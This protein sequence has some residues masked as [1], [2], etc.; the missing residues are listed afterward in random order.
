MNR[1]SIVFALTILLAVTTS[2][3]A[4]V[5]SGRV[6]LSSYL[7]ERSELDSTDTR[8]WQNSGTIGLRLGRI[9]GQDLEVVTT[10]R[11]RLDSRNQGDNVDDYRVYD[12]F[13]RWRKLGGVIDATVGRHRISW[14]SG[15]VGI[16]GGSADLRFLKEWEVGGYIGS[17]VPEDGRFKSTDFDEGHAIGARLGR[18][19]KAV[20]T[21]F[22]TFSERRVARSYGDTDV[23]TLASRI[24]GVDWRRSF[25][26]FG[27]LYANVLYDQ[28]RMRISRAQVSGRWDATPSVSVQGQ[29]RYRRPDLAYN[30]IFWVF[31]DSDYMEER[32]RLLIR[33][34]DHWSMTVGGAL[35]DIGDDN[36]TRFDI[37]ASHRYLSAM[38]HAK[39]G[40]SGTT[41]A[42]TG[43]AMY[44]VGPM[45]TLRGGSRYASYE[46]YED[47]EESNAEASVWAG[48]RWNWMPQSTW[49][50]E[51]QFL[52]QDIKT[53]TTFAGD[54]SDFRL[55]ARF[56]WWFFNRL[57]G[58]AAVE[59]GA[60]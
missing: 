19:C 48:V 40:T 9:S 42:L 36:A 25:P 26:S 54:E 56:S 15:S 3:S 27:S 10:M 35:V 1:A 11:G 39:T 24:F 21:F 22:L 49:D 47:Q 53:M 4:A 51:A 37:G 14:A 2:T 34:N 31:G 28:P 43:D 30:S 57:G 23:H 18:R 38:I 29:V 58:P 13:A 5:L 60:Q 17:L 52:T 33:I 12:L 55:I 7:W 20:G 59:G 32:L 8:H 46:L 44:P 16:D 41:V 6:G 50:L 45:W